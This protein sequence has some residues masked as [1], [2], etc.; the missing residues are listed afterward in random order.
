MGFCAVARIARPNQLVRMNHHSATPQ[1]SDIEKAI[2][3]GTLMNSDPS[4]SDMV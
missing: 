4:Y 1:A 2:R 3:Y